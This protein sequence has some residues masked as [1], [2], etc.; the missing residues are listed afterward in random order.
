MLAWGIFSNCIKIFISTG[1]FSAQC[2]LYLVCFLVTLM[3]TA[4]WLPAP[5]EVGLN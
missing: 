3:K 1:A 4:V 2:V 5:D